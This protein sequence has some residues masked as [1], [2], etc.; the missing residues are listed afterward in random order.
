MVYRALPESCQ[1]EIDNEVGK[2]ELTSYD[3]F[4]DFV[5][6]MSRHA[7]YKKQSAPKPLS[8]TL[9]RK[10]QAQCLINLRLINHKPSQY[11]Q[12]MIGLNGSKEQKVNKLSK[13]DMSSQ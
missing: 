4:M 7:R 8:A 9:Y 2:G 13:T 10:A 3:G 5:L 6:N 1:K 11:T 12:S